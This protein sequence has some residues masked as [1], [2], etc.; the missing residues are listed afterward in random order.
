MSEVW[1]PRGNRVIR[2]ESKTSCFLGFSVMGFQPRLAVG[3]R[4]DLPLQVLLGHFRGQM[5]LGDASLAGG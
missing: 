5:H 3:S 4:G 2:L 1:E